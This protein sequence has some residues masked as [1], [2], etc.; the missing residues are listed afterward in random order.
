DDE[1]KVDQREDRGDRIDGEEGGGQD[2]EQEGLRRNDRDIVERTGEAVSDRSGERVL[3]VGLRYAL[4]TVERA[5]KHVVRDAFSVAPLDTGN[6][7]CKQAGQPQSD[8]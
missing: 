1:R 6:Q 4:E 7:A 5:G 3:Q 8:E 2:H